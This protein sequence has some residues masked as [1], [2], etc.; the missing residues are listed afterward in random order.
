LR[1]G[2]GRKKGVDYRGMGEKRRQIKNTDYR[3]AYRGKR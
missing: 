3:H 1:R 2:K